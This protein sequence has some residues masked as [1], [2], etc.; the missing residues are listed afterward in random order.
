MTGKHTRNEDENIVS[1]K[2]PK[3]CQ[4]IQEDSEPSTVPSSSLSVEERAREEV[5]AQTPP[6][7]G[8]VAWL[9][10]RSSYPQEGIPQDADLAILA[11]VAFFLAIMNTWSVPNSAQLHLQSLLTTIAGA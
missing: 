11:V 5:V 7:G 3:S 4:I 1:S 10:G 2:A 9:A 6:E 8:L